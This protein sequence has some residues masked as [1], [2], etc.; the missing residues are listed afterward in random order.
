MLVDVTHQNFHVLAKHMPFI[1]FKAFNSYELSQQRAYGEGFASVVT[2]SFIYHFITE[3]TAFIFQAE[4]HL[5][6]FCDILV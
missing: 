4:Q 3:L 5:D 1:W 6:S 2:F